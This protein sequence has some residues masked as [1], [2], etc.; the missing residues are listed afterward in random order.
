[1]KIERLF[2]DFDGFDLVLKAKTPIREIV[3]WKTWMNDKSQIDKI[4]QIAENNTLAILHFK[5][6]EN[7]LIKEFAQIKIMEF[8]NETIEM[9]INNIPES[10]IVTIHA[11]QLL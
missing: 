9:D 1:M 4:K 3:L 5:D 8:P 2:L 6:D 7:P 11:S 10:E